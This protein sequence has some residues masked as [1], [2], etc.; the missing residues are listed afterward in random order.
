MIPLS[1]LNLQTG[2]TPVSLAVTSSKTAPDGTLESA[3]VVAP[4]VLSRTGPPAAPVWS[5]TPIRPASQ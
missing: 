4:F 3:R 5:Q 2:A 1:V